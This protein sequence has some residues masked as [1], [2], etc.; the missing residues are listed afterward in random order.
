MTKYSLATIRRKALNAGYRVEK[1]FQHYLCNDSVC[2]D[3]N[4]ERLTGFNVWDSTI[5]AYV[6]GC[7]ND[8]YDHLWTL[9]DVENFLKSEYDKVGLEY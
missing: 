5:N 9:Q 4:G 6:W 7:Y 3:W 2:T 8:N 1:G